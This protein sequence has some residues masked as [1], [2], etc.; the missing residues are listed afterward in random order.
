MAI[1][2][3]AAFLTECMLGETYVYITDLCFQYRHVIENLCLFKVLLHVFWRNK[4]FTK[5]SIRTS[6]KFR[7]CAVTDL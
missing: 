1:S 6:L 2:T 7:H 4:I 3:N 5:V